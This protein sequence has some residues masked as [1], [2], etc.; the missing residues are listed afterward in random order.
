MRKRII[1]IINWT[2]LLSKTLL[3]GLRINKI[4]RLIVNGKDY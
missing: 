2:K 3:L 4:E 1:D